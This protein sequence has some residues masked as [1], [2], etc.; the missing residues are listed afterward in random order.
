MRHV[1]AEAETQE[2]EASSTP[3]MVCLADVAP[4]KVP[5]LWQNKIPLGRCTLLVSRPGEGKTYVSQDAASRVTTGTPWPDGTVCP[6]GDVILICGEDDASDT[7]RP[8]LDA[9][10]AD[11]R[12][13]HLFSMV[14]R[15]DRKGK[16]RDLLFTLQDV[17]A[18]EAAL[19]AHL[20]CKLLVIDPIGSFLGGDTDAHRDNEVRSVLAPVAKLAEIYGPAVL[21]I[22][23]RRKSTATNADDLALGSRAFTG[24]CRAVWHI[25]RDPD[26]KRR[27]LFL[28]GKNNLAEEGNGLA[29]TIEG[30]PPTVV[31]ERDPVQM[32]ADDALANEN[33]TSRPGPQPEARNAAADWLLKVLASGPVTSGDKDHPAPDTI[34]ALAKEADLKWATVRRAADALGVRREKAPVSHVWQWRLPSTTKQGAQVET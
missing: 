25:S 8:R 17:T 4:R 13:V 16:P 23:H 12:K 11:C 29:F 32:R 10:R 22:A 31:W 14:R 19:K 9:H 18:L 3:V 15:L 28:P 6:Q 24:L 1:E 30:D 33:E 20:D 27:R 2:P 5:W 26:N 34:R 21:I 7:I